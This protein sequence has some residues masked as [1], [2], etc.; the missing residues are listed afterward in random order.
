MVLQSQ[1]STEN[2]RAVAKIDRDS[3]RRIS[4]WSSTRSE[5]LAVDRQGIVVLERTDNGRISVQDGRDSD[6]EA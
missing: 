6:V 3:V 5:Q 2:I 1:P 4:A